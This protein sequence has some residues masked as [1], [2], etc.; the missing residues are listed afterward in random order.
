MVD[1][2]RAGALRA[3]E[4]GEVDLRDLRVG[5]QPER[6]HA[7][8][9]HAVA[10]VVEDDPHRARAEFHRAVDLVG[11]QQGPVADDRHRPT[12]GGQRRADD[13]GGGVTHGPKPGAGPVSVRR[14]KP[15]PMRRPQK[16]VAGLRQHRCVAAI[17]DP[18]LQR[19]HQRFGT[20]QAVAALLHRDRSVDAAAPAWRRRSTAGGGRAR[21]AAWLRRRRRR[22]AWA[23]RRTRRPA[24]RD[25]RRRE[26]T[27]RARRSGDPRTRS[28]PPAASRGPARVAACT[29]PGSASPT[30]VQPDRSHRRTAGRPRGRSPC[31]AA[32]TSP[33][34]ACDARASRS[35]RRHRV[36][37]S[38]PR[39]QTGHHAAHRRRRRLARAV[40]S[41]RTP[42][43]SDD[44]RLCGWAA[45][46]R[47]TAVS[48]A[49]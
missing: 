18:V 36:R 43:P 7:L 42:D 22:R 41:P 40:V 20:H 31:R 25:P 47:C 9:A 34:P 44:S 24:R 15:Q 39:S 3:S 12:P 19:V 6:V 45:G 5:R 49:R 2:R 8:R 10:A 16:R 30:R 33:A 13:T 29:P 17:D 1:T 26:R 48:S 11:H 23:R 4:R 28:V 37:R 38:R 14:R 46:A 27:L 35:R 32:S 21:P